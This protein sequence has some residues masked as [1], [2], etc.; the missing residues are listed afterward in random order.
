MF[1]LHSLHR[2]QLTPCA[3]LNMF[4]R[5]WEDEFCNGHIWVSQQKFPPHPPKKKGEDKKTGNQTTSRPSHPCMVSLH[6]FTTQL[7][8]SA[9]LF[10][11]LLPSLAPFICLN[12][13]VFPSTKH[14]QIYQ[15]WMT[16]IVSP[17][18]LLASRLCRGAEG[19]KMTITKP[20]RKFRQFSQ[21]W[22]VHVGEANLMQKNHCSS[23]AAIYAVNKTMDSKS[24]I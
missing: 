24:W 13:G 11:I 8:Y 17:T 10:M 4:S 2:P 22:A 20:T 19:T 18:Y 3:R 5:W 1:K 6:T 21:P 16:Y 9:H 15:P 12:Q 23:M 7:V 14:G